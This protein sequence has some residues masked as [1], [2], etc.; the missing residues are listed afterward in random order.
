M[1][2]YEIGRFD[3]EWMKQK[4]DECPETISINGREYIKTPEGHG[5]PI[6]NLKRIPADLKTEGLDAIYNALFPVVPVF[7]SSR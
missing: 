2:Y 4:S 6:R 1:F 3:G 5:A 7:N